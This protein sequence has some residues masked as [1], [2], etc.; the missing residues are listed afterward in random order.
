MLMLLLL[1]VSELNH[2]H[3]H[4]M[5]MGSNSLYLSETLFS[6]PPYILCSIFILILFMRIFFLF[7]VCTSRV[8]SPCYMTRCGRIIFFNVKILGVRCL[9][10]ND[11]N[12]VKINN[13]QVSCKKKIRVDVTSQCIILERTFSSFM[14]SYIITS[15][16]ELH[17]IS[18]GDPFAGNENKLGYKRM[19]V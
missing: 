16:C 7:Q 1:V 2:R 4:P 3:K 5:P 6:M 15:V 18:H 13:K 19:R 12:D 17:S 8:F 14:S 11:I 9:S 10:I